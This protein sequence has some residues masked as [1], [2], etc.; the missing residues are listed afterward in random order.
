MSE[1]TVGELLKQLRNQKSD[2][3]MALP[4][5]DMQVMGL[6]GLKDARPTLLLISDVA[7]PELESSA[8]IEVTYQQEKGAGHY[9]FLTVTDQK[10]EDLFG[11]FCTDLLSIMDG[12]SD[13]GAAISRMACRYEA[14]RNFWKRPQGELSEEQ[15][16]GLVGE[17]L[18]FKRCLDKGMS[19]DAVVH[20]WIGPHGGDQ[21]FVFTNSWAEIKTI[22]QGTNEVQI[23]S[24]EQLVNPSRI[25]EQDGIVG[26]LAI[27]RLHSDP[28]G[29]DCITLS[30]LYN[31][32][33]DQLEAYPHAAVNFMNSVDM[34]GADIK[35]GSKENKLRLK[36]LEFSLYDVNKNNFPRIIRDETIPSAVTKL[37]YSLSIPALEQW[38]I[39]E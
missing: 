27:I 26:H 39:T 19:P 5:Y 2:K 11:K 29:D 1:N 17:L 12:A 15:V 14:W 30:K 38:K 34:I 10:F 33:L 28:V 9:L 18:Y 37:K 31:S 7:F 23:S 25:A 21:D 32:I 6:I 24:I 4:G 22:R 16:R 13:S 8:A 36:V 3:F 35:G 20:A